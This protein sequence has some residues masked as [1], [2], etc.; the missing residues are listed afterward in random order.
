[1]Q[2]HCYE[3]FQKQRQGL[4]QSRRAGGAYWRRGFCV[5]GVGRGSRLRGGQRGAAPTEALQSWAGGVGWGG[6]G[7]LG[8]QRHLLQLFRH[9]VH[10]QG[11]PLAARREGQR[12]INE[13]GSLTQ[14][15][16]G[17]S[18]VLGPRVGRIARDSQY[19]TCTPVEGASAGVD[20]NQRVMQRQG[21]GDDTNL[22]AGR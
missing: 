9:I 19:S 3:H 6:G 7:C 4:K 13:L 12:V 10:V 5:E 8:H 1:M 17:H 2:R 18:T 20:G 11:A 21:E 16:T 22:Q 14:L 15:V